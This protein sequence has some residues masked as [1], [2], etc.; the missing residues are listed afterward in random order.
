MIETNRVR[1]FVFLCLLGILQGTGSAVETKTDA[2]KR[3]P[4][5][6][7]AVGMT[8]VEGKAQTAQPSKA[9]VLAAVRA[10]GAGGGSLLAEALTGPLKGVEEIV[11]GVTQPFPGAFEPFRPDKVRDPIHLAKRK[12]AQLC[13]LNL[14]TGKVTVLLEDRT[15]E[16]RDLAVSYDGKRAL[17][18]YG[19][20]G[21]VGIHVHEINLDG[22]GLRRI[23]PDDAECDVNPAYLPNGEIVF[24]STRSHHFVGCATSYAPSLHRCRA[25]GGGLVPISASLE[26][27][28]G[29]SVLADGRLMFLHWEYYNRGTHH[30]HPVYTCNPDGTGLAA[31][32]GNM[33]PDGYGWWP[34]GPRQMPGSNHIVFSILYGDGS[35]G[36]PHFYDLSFGPDGGK[37]DALKAVPGAKGHDLFPLGGSWLLAVEKDTVLLCDGKGRQ[38][39]IYRLAVPCLNEGMWAVTPQPIRARPREPV[40]P[41]HVDWNGAVGKF[42]LA[43]VYNSRNLPGIK[44]GEI[45]RL[46]VLEWLPTPLQ[47]WPTMRGAWF[48][49]RI[50]GTVPVEADGSAYF[51]APAGRA[52][53]FVALD[54]RGLS[55]KH[56]QSAAHVMPG[57][58]A[59]CVG[60]HEPRNQSGPAAAAVLAVRRPARRIEPY[61]GIPD[62]LDYMEDI[63]PI[64]DRHCVRCHNPD[65]REGGVLMTADRGGGGWGGNLPHSH[66]SLTAAGQIVD[67][68]VPNLWGNV[69]PRRMGSGG[70]PVMRKLDGSHHDVKV[71]AREWNTVALW[72]DVMIPWRRYYGEQDAGGGGSLKKEAMDVVE[73]RCFSCHQKDVA[74]RGRGFRAG[75]RSGEEGR[76]ILFYREP[77]PTPESDLGALKFWKPENYER[78]FR[79]AF[80]RN[81]HQLRRGAAIMLNMDR[82]E[83]SLLLLAPLSKSAGGYATATVDEV[84]SGKVKACPVVFQNTEDPD[85]KAILAGIPRLPPYKKP[86]NMIGDSRGSVIGRFREWGLL[87]PDAKTFDRHKMWDQYWESLRWK[88]TDRKVGSDGVVRTAGKHG[89]AGGNP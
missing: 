45:K 7:P 37:G 46:L 3:T 48:L 27:E 70:S 35:G 69:P 71:S 23:T 89:E 67:C 50:M 85:Y 29:V 43:D 42:M 11:F 55:V 26:I 30:V 52:Y 16:L 57:E 40:I 72:L 54:E 86:D 22:T 80:G 17:F 39:G 62:R 15:G 34:E 1:R 65:K 36:S 61:E 44:P 4:T 38:Q 76:N 13:K 10:P 51:E 8:Q 20:G 84:K 25:D 82:P 88:P 60:C 49:H 31:A 47:Y 21:T 66:R 63:Q 64:W 6:A 73:R 78:D 32:Y 79:E 14:R 81:E 24:C 77:N 68:R 9:P 75:F 87:S 74:D 2:P 18:A 5:A 41:D 58:T 83:T 56:M 59:G 53:A 19:K 33:H 28:R 12:G